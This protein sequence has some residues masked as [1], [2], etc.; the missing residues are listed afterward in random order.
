V[1][2]VAFVLCLLQATPGDSDLP[3]FEAASV[4][5]VDVSKPQ[6]LSAKVYPGGRMR[7]TSKRLTEIAAAA[8]M[9][10][11]YRVEGPKGINHYAYTI[12]ALPPEDDSLT[13]ARVSVF[14]TSFPQI[15]LLRLRAL[16]LER[17]QLR[18]HFETRDVTRYD[19]V[20]GKGGP[21]MRK[22]TLSDERLSC[23]DT[24][25]DSEGRMMAELARDLADFYLN[26]EVVDRT[27]LT[28][29]YAYSFSFQPVETTPEA[30]TEALPS[31]R[32]GIKDIGLA[33][34]PRRS[35]ARFLVID[36][37]EQPASN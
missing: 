1:I 27:D 26:T 25:I 9:L 14:H 29:P 13:E 20:V 30:N 24:R 15:S 32:D 8:W 7:I 37:F 36:H 21:K 19:L 4:R 18:Y 22:T 10:P 33:L 31:L 34:V 28:E 5:L 35:K 6:H 11:D 17:F 3:T 12:E 16:L 23:Y 2:E